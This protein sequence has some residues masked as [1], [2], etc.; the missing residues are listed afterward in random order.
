MDNNYTANDIVSLSAGRAFREKIGMYL[1]ADRQE[2]INLGLRELIVNV[3]DEYEVYKPKNPYLKI[4]LLTKTREI[5]VSDNMRGIPVGIRDDGMN[6][7]TAAFLIPHS[8]GKHTEGVYSSAVGING[9]GNKIVCHTAEFLEVTVSRDGNIYT[10]SFHSTDEGASAD[11]DVK[12][13]PRNDNSDFTGT[14][15]HY[16]PD[17]KVYG[18]IFIDI[19]SLRVTLKEMAMFSTGLHIYLKVD[20]KEEEFYSQ[21]G[22]IDGLSKENRLSKPFSYH[23]ETPDCK[24]DLALQ[25]VSKKGQIRGYA[26]NLFMP[27]GGAFIS[28][29]K[30]SLTRTFNSIAK[31]KYDGDTI[32][33]VLDGFVSVKV[34]MGQF[35]NQQ[36]TAL[37]NPEARTATSTAISNALKEFAVKRKDDFDKV[38]E[39]LAKV[40]KAEAAAERARR[41]VLDNEKEQVAAQ[42]K[43]ILNVDKLRDAR[44]LGKDS[45][46][47]LCEGLSAGGSMSIG[48]DANK[49]GILMLRGK[50]KNLLNCTIEEGLQNEEVKLFQQALGVIY[51]RKTPESQL[52]YGKIAIASDS[53]FDG[54]HIGL[55]ILAMTH[56]ICPNFLTE[57][58][59]YWLRAPIYKV[60]TRNKNYYYYSEEEFIKHPNGNIIKYKGLGQMSDNDLKESMFS[61]EWQRLEPISFSEEGLNDLIKLMGPKVDY[62]KEFVYN[63]IDFSKFVIE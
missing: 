58:R 9:E 25:W 45:I 59:I 36:K 30:T 24:V 7:L 57:N 43:K 1:S 62:R 3:Q 41:Q 20:G 5:I 47:L 39:L 37:A 15:I 32:R 29:F 63:N 49:Y 18:N 11:Y 8:G 50:C 28:G 2:A 53:D 60:E 51:G 34:K 6:S 27:D 56:I 42:K 44:K 48:R 14:W 23:Y 46:L 40:A 26:N 55:L 16:R 22:L 13:R 12:V 31:T 61:D 38:I 52:R 4:E 33:D 19:D 35:T 17:E 21:S 10:Q 54:S